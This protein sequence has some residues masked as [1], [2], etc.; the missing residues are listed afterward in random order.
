MLFRSEPQFHAAGRP[1]VT[2]EVHLGEPEP[3]IEADPDLLRA[4][5]ENLL[6][7]CLDAMPSGGTLAIG[8]REKD[9]VV[10][11]EVSAKGASLSAEDCQR[12]F[13]P[14]G[15]APEGM[16]GLG[17]ATAHAVVSDHGGRISA[18]STAGAGTTFRLEFSAVPGGAS[19]PTRTDRAR[20]TQLETARQTPTASAPPAPPVASTQPPPEVPV[21][22]VPAEPVQV[23]I[24]AAETAAASEEVPSTTAEASSKLDKPSDSARPFRGLTYTE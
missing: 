7:H 11:I 17:L 13:V 3:V 18:E 21:A 2:P 12:L 1:P 14:A 24:V 4:A 5:L 6:L 10:R 23:T 20:Q 8:T 22:A 16:T 9:A 15:S 19:R